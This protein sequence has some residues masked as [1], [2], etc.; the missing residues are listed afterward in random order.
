MSTSQVLDRTFHLYRNNFV[1]FAGI[2][3]IAPA[4]S[5]IT[6]LL[7]L[8]LVGP[9][10]AP[11]EAVTDP[12]VASRIFT[13]YLLRAGMQMVITLIV[14]AIGTA[15]ATGATTYAVSMVHLGKATTI[16]ESYAKIRPMFWR[17]L[18]LITAVLLITLGPMLIVEGVAITWAIL[19]I[20]SIAEGG[21]PPV[22][23]TL[24]LLV[25]L[26][27]G[28]LAG[29]VWAIYALCRY[30]LAVP[31]CVLEHLPVRQ[32]IRRGR[33][34]VKNSMLRV[35]GVYLLTFLMVVVLTTVLELPA[36]IGGSLFSGKA[37]V[38][39]GGFALVWVL[40]AQFLSKT[41]AGPIV[42]IAIALLYYDQRVRKEAFDLQL[43][44][45][46]VGQQLPQPAIAASAPPTLG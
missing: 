1:L 21:P 24:A 42:T 9:A 45:E 3:L 43:M 2:A 13:E 5:L 36:W 22:S 37:G 34:L 11:P 20:R 4:L 35:F 23:T 46:A 8:W 41:I 38:H 33:F 26:L 25:L 6:A 18:R 40:L 14:Y 39:L 15:L 17:I 16:A 7:Q 12:Q 29:V 32:A 10:P 31:A 28:L 19:M 27:L 44:M 30:A